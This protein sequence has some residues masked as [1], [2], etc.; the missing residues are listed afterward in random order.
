MTPFLV[1]AH[2]QRQPWEVRGEE[3]TPAATCIHRVYPVRHFKPHMKLP[4]M[5][6]S[7][8]SLFFRWKMSRA[9]WATYSGNKKMPVPCLNPEWFGMQQ[10][11][12]WHWGSWVLRLTVHNLEE[13]SAEATWW[14]WRSMTA[15]GTAAM[16]RYSSSHS[17]CKRMPIASFARCS[18]ELQ[19]ACGQPNEEDL[20]GT[21]MRK[22]A[23]F[24]RYQNAGNPMA[25]PDLIAGA[26]LDP[27]FLPTVTSSFNQ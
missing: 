20:S 25:C 3:Q 5:L 19:S 6:H 24:R 14:S 27:F 18:C 1:F 15:C 11:Q 23:P 4:D 2:I 22:S 16:F 10:S 17:S 7:H 13:I 26:Q 21:S 9:G 8:A 12:W